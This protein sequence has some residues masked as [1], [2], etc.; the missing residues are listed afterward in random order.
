MSKKKDIVKINKIIKILVKYPEGVWIRQ[1]SKES[2]LAVST[3]H[4][5]ITQILDEII[6]NIGVKDK[7]SRYFGIRIIKLKPKI[8]ET[9]EKKGFENIYN[10]L[11]MYNKI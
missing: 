5:Y 1:I 9:I 7:K 4:Y 11:K 2:N 10:Y 6:D 8:R 3:V